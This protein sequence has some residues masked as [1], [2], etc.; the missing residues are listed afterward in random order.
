[1]RYLILLLLAAAIPLSSLAADSTDVS[2]H[3]SGGKRWALSS[4]GKHAKKAKKEHK[5]KRS[6]RSSKGQHRAKSNH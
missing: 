6:K 2:R 3:N 1:M 4:G 5:N